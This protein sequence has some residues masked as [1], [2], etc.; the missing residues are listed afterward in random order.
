[1]TDIV[2]IEKLV[3]DELALLDVSD[4]PAA[5]EALKYARKLDAL[6]EDGDRYV[7]QTCVLAL[8]ARLELVHRLAGRP[9]SFAAQAAARRD[10]AARARVR[11][12]PPD[13]DRFAH[14]RPEG[15]QLDQVSPNP[16]KSL[17]GALWATASAD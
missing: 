2:A 10:E 13:V 4:R 7:A 5:A 11:A 12:L 17:G 16:E 8:A 9:T 3:A 15:V 6:P 1:M 14:R